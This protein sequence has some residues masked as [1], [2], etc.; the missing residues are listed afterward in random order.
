M[1]IN[2]IGAGISGLTS[3]CYLQ[4]N[5]FE[6]QIFEKHSIPGGLCTSW[7]KGE[8]TFD[9][10]VHW[11]LGSD[12]GSS[13]YKM[14]SELLH[15]ES[16]PFHHHDARI[17]VELK[18]NKDKYGSSVFHV[19]NNLDRLQEYMTDLAPED[20]KIIRGFVKNIRIIQQFELP[21]VMDKLP[22]IPSMIRGIKMAR[23]LR[24]L[25][26]FL[27]LNK[28]TTH[29]LAKKFKN[30]FLREGIETIF[31]GQEVKLLIFSFPTA[32][33][34]L[35]SA[36][37]PIGGSLSWAKRL[38]NRYTELGG[39]IHYNTPVKKILTESNK[40]TGLL[41]RNNVIHNSDMVVS[42]ADW[43]HT[44]FDFLEGKFVDKKM[45]DLKEGKK[46]DLFYSAMMVSFGINKSYEGYPH[47][48][49]FPI[50]GTLTSPCGTTWDRLEVHIYNY[51]PTLAPKCKTVI[52]CCFFTRCGEYWINLRKKERKKYREE[53]TKFC[54]D[55]LDFLDQKLPGAKEAIEEIDFGTPATFERYTHN[56]QGSTQGWLPENNLLAK[57]PVRYTLPGLAN[58]YYASH[59]SQPGGGLPIAINKGRDVTKLICKHTK[60][61][62]KV[63][64][65]MF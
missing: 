55:V 57:S 21:P 38:A 64:K 31:D 25:F 24:F 35:K 41:V 58:F 36:G 65:P 49:R 48:S 6:T 19:Y 26:L 20:E 4:M 30:P 16:I 2:I 14:W 11:I 60:R 53:K 12:K 1:K 40:A 17:H 59:W 9:G 32:V 43:N 15:M 34:D 54:N 3:G 22:L 61:E 23:Y 42:A 46:L 39:K 63:I 29:T 28:E 33:F 51:D 56:W 45:L 52:T 47:F 27:R 37:Y 5:G 62:F 7:K 8:Y 10:C 50:E 18:K 44:I 13:F